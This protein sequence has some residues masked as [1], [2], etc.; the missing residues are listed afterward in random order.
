MTD[1]EMKFKLEY[2]ALMLLTERNKEASEALEAVLDELQTR[3]DANA[4]KE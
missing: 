1:K 4:G 3:I 2:M